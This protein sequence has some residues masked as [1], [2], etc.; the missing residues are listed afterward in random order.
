MMSL[1]FSNADNVEGD[2]FVSDVDP[3]LSESVDIIVSQLYDVSKSTVNSRI[4][5]RSSMF[6]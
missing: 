4:G 5:T 3:K 6:H 2:V 1:I